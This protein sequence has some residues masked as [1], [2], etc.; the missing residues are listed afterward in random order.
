MRV[1]GTTTIFG[2]CPP[3]TTFIC[4]DDLENLLILR[5][6]EMLAGFPSA[7]LPRQAYHFRLRGVGGRLDAFGALHRR[8]E[9]N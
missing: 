6:P 2:N 1:L 4:P 5:A 8:T 9:K 3:A 7:E